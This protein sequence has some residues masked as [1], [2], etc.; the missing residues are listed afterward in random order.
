MCPQGWL[1]SIRAREDRRVM[2]GSRDTRPG[3]I[4]AVSAELTASWLQGEAGEAWKE[5][6][7]PA[8]ATSMR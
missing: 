5:R 7:G 6:A 4:L 8:P 3:S 1:S 2:W